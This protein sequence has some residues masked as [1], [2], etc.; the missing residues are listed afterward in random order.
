MSK[1]LLTPSDLR[2]MI[3]SAIPPEGAAELGPLLDLTRF[4]VPKSHSRALNLSVPIVVG[5]RGTGKSYWW[6]SLQMR[7]HR[8]ELAKEAPDTRIRANTIVIPGFW[9]CCHDSGSAQP[10]LLSRTEADG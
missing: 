6:T 7:S 1:Y 3:C 4:F 2:A 8:E 5:D 10:G 9:Q